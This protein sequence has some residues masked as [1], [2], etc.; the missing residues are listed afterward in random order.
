MFPG[1][2]G[3]M[4][5]NL[6]PRIFTRAAGD[7][8][9][10]GLDASQCPTNCWSRRG[11]SSTTPTSPRPT[12]ARPPTMRLTGG[13]LNLAMIDYFLNCDRTTSPWRPDRRH[14]PSITSLPAALPRPTLPWPTPAVAANFRFAISPS[15]MGIDVPAP[16][17]TRLPSTRIPWPARRARGRTAAPALRCR[18]RTSNT[19]P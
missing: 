8:L 1:N 13:L 12:A 7:Y 2:T 16:T 6:I 15:S 5:G 18:R 4:E 3:G 17:G 11:R 9:A 10:I 19:T 14:C